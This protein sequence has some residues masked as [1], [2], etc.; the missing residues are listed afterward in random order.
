[1]VMRTQVRVKPGSSPEWAESG[2]QT[3]VAEQ[4]QGPIHRV[5][6]Y[7][8]EPLTHTPKKRFY[9]WVVSGFR[10]F[11]IDFE[12]LVGQFH[13]GSLQT[14]PEAVHALFQFF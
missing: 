10:Q 3:K 14:L 2:N 5:Q 12:T 7:R 4:P 1:M 8:G 13:S 9:I 6:R 11:L